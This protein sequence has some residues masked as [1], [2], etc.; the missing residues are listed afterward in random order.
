MFPSRIG[1]LLYLQQ[2]DRGW[3]V[4]V[5]YVRREA[6]GVGIANMICAKKTVAMLPVCFFGLL[7]S[8]VA[9]ETAVVQTNVWIRSDS[10]APAQAS[11]A[12]NWSLGRVPS[13]NDV[14][15]LSRYYSY[16]IVW[17][18][19]A[20]SSVAGWIQ[21]DGYLA[22]VTFETSKDGPMR[23]FSVTGDMY[24]GSGAVT[25]PANTDSD[26]W[27]LNLKVSGDMTVAEGAYVS[28]SA[29]GY[30]SGFGPSPGVLFGDGASHGGLGAPCETNEVRRLGRTYDSIINPVLPGSGGSSIGKPGGSLNGG[31]VAVLDVGGLLKVFGAI[32]A[33][34]DGTDAAY[35]FGGAAGG[36]VNIKAAGGIRV[37]GSIS[38]NG[39]RAYNG[40]GGGGGGG[41]ISIV[42]GTPGER[43]AFDCSNRKVTAFGGCGDT[44]NFSSASADRHIRGAAGTVYMENLSE[45]GMFS[46][47]GT[48]YVIDGHRTSIAFTTIPSD[49]YDDVNECRDAELYV[50]SMGYVTIGGATRFRK[51]KFASSNG[52][53]LNG[54]YVQTGS[55]ESSIGGKAVVLDTPG[56]HSSNDDPVLNP[57][58]FNGGTLLITTYLKPF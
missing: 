3:L 34:G 35:N 52:M 30:G 19:K 47:G 50:G 2:T 43:C 1:R 49:M 46:G 33:D 4:P 8:G 42:S 23:E 38:A 55:V 12:S 57:V 11:T 58:F 37:E 7:V 48:V 41:R 22:I 27:W 10:S 24:I 21:E 20:P 6:D 36:S 56:T 29:K 51:I 14:V 5:K 15:R 9:G 18:E 39:A 17:D 44:P 16:S 31:G 54:N 32:C 53:D 13:S 45:S 26:H 25:H 28:V 40:G